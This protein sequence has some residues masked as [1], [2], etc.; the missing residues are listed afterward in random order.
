LVW[1]STPLSHTSNHNPAIYMSRGQGGSGAAAVGSGGEQRRLRRRRAAAARRS[2]CERWRRSGGGVG[3]GSVRRS[4][5]ERQ[6]WRRR[7]AAVMRGDG[8]TRSER[9]VNWGNAPC[10]HRLPGL[11]GGGG[12]GRWRRRAARSHCSHHIFSCFLLLQRDQVKG[13]RG[14]RAGWARSASRRVA[15]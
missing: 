7:G 3:G 8:L 14:R 11:G 1:I 4:G 10:R 12:G 13:E 5:C 2:G 9:A 15:V 6:W